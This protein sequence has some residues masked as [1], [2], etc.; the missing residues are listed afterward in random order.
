V[1]IDKSD[2][3]LAKCKANLK[4]AGVSRKVAYENQD[5]ICNI[6]MD[7]PSVVIFCLTLQFL[8]LLNREKILNKIC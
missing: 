8:R 6:E 4:V 7:N 5:L 3:M 1:G 2:E